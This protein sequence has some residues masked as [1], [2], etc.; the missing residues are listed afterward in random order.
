LKT[1]IALAFYYIAIGF[2]VACAAVIVVK[3]IFWPPCTQIGNTCAIDPWS[4]AGL[5]GTVLAVSATV[6]AILGAVAV[7]AW[8][9]S[10]NDRVNER[11]KK[12]YKAQKAEINTQVDT[13]L[14][15]QR[16]KV[17]AQ[18]EGFQT[19]FRSLE[20]RVTLVRKQV[21]TLN[22][23]MR[24]VEA[25]SID[26]IT[27]VFGAGFLEQWAQ[28]STQ[29]RKFP[30]IP[31]R[32]A[33]NYLNEVAY[34]LPRVEDGLVNSERD[35]KISDDFFRTNFLN[36]TLSSGVNQYSAPSL[37]NFQAEIN[38]SLD[39]LTKEYTPLSDAIA[40]WDGALRWLGLGMDYM[41][42]FEPDDEE[43]A[44]PLAKLQERV[45]A[46]RP[47]VEQL[48]ENRD[49]LITRTKALLL[50]VTA[51][52]EARQINVAPTETQD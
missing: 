39:S 17:D 15:D 9:T 23:S 49:Q 16:E 25:I 33:E 20:S 46:L 50:E 7:A 45:E 6:L 19:S 34:V 38:K 30:R 27:S 35:L 11:V 44:L 22:E 42:V 29:G 28:K 18:L 13:L 24:D 32:M 31:L 43:L 26:G 51:Y 47:R 4:T 14:A 1:N 8:W 21:L 48:K 12:L 40:S 37:Q 52:V 3:L 10:L 41:E 5:A 36:A 2:L